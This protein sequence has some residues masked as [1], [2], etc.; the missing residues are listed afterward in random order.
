MSVFNVF[1]PVSLQIIVRHFKLFM[2]EENSHHIHYHYSLSSLSSPSLL[3]LFLL[4]VVVV[5]LFV[6]ILFVILN[7]V[8]LGV[9]S[10]I[11]YYKGIICIV[12]RG[13]LTSRI[14]IM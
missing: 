11:I 3:L 12:Q 6:L 8:V 13:I 10:I 9:E 7:V 2:K 5:A 14:I 4:F 1:Q